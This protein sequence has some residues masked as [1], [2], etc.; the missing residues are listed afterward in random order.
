MNTIKE[1]LIVRGKPGKVYEAL[2]TPTGYRGWWSKDCQIAQKPGEESAL[3]F[4][5]D[6]NIVSMRF[7]L[8]DTLPERS[9]RW[10]CVGHDMASWVG[11]TLKWDLVSDGDATEVSFEHGGWT[12]Q[13]PEPVVQGWRYFM[14]SL[15]SYVE[16]GQG[17]PW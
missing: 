10:T 11:T 17:Q 1:K 6:G 7:R 14:G 8:D 9:V 12:G 13:A 5:K 2:T 16:T 4:N 15:R 3:K